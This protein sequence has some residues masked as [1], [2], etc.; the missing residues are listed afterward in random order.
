MLAAD[1]GATIEKAARL[2]SR[3]GLLLR[4]VEHRAALAALE[5]AEAQRLCLR[6]L[7]VAVLGA[8]LLLLA[9][10][11]VALLVAAV[12]WDT[13]YR[14]LALALLGGVELVA[15]VAGVWFALARWRRWAPFEHTRDQLDKDA[16]CLREILDQTN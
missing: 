16:S 1:L 12:Y 5:L 11:T 7:T 3:A 8:V 9:G 14:V 2:G 6:T 15:G 4:A 13:E 10:G